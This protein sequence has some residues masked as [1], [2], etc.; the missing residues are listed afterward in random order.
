MTE[1]ETDEQQEFE[2]RLLDRDRAVSEEHDLTTEALRRGSGLDERLREERGARDSKDEVDVPTELDEIDEEADM[3]ADPSLVGSEDGPFIPAEE[4]AHPR[5]GG[6]AGRDGSS[7]RHDRLNQP[8]RVRA[9][10]PISAP[11]NSTIH[12]TTGYA[13]QRSI[14][15]SPM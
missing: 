2:D 11:P 10:A 8:S 3:V 7:R 12:S 9:S 13:T 4:A 15:P 5:R 14:P 6:S 1:S